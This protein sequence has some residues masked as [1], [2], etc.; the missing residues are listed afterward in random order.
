MSVTMNLSPQQKSC[1]IIQKKEIKYNLNFKFCR[2][3]C[4][5]ILFPDVFPQL[6]SH[7]VR[8]VF[9]QPY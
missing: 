4:P 1:V 2:K 3:N 8:L 7:R 9:G 6:F 5:T